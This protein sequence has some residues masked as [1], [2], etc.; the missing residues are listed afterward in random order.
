MTV[1]AHG[2]YLGNVSLV[3]KESDF[4][5]ANESVYTATTRSGNIPTAPTGV[6]TRSTNVK[7]AQP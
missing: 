5:A 6:T 4:T 2:K 1:P 3:M 7:E